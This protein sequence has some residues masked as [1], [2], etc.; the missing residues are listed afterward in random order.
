M[1][2]FSETLIPPEI[3]LSCLLSPLTIF[4][5]FCFEHPLTF[6]HRKLPSGIFV[7]HISIP[8]ALFCDQ[9]IIPIEH[10]LQNTHGIKDK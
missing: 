2:L 5:Y 7:L 8:H 1:G 4:S 9:T 6:W 10:C 3:F